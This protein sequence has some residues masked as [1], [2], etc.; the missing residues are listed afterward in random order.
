MP[1][2]KGRRKLMIGEHKKNDGNILYLNYGG[3]FMGI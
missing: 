1:G 2:I 3:D